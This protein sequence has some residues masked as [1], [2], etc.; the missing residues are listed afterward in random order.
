MTLW[1]LA[2]QARQIDLAH[3]FRVGMPQ[4]PNHPPFRMV[5]ER[6]H[7]DMVRLDGGS[8]AN[9]MIVTG[10]HV[11]T[12]ID[13]LAH[14]SQDG[15]VFGGVPANSLLTARGFS[16]LGVD[17]LPPFVGRGV[18]LDVTAVHGV[19]ALEPGYEVTP[20]DLIA[21]QERIGCE[22]RPGDVVLVGTG[23][24]RHWG[25]GDTFTGLTGG[26]AGPGLE[27]GKW[28][29]QFSP[30]MVGG[31]AITFERIAPGAG[32]SLLPVHNTMLVENGINIIETMNLAPLIDAAAS[33]FL[34]ILAG[35]NLAGA[36]GSPV[37]PL[38]LIPSSNRPLSNTP[39]GN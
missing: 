11:G 4:S 26:V 38:A 19:D 8:A 17:D 31:E 34:L 33:E 13:A 10:G 29:A 25:D 22:I 24:S 20:D 16:R 7:G 36:T 14:V 37:R 18:L 23:W 3:P 12:H 32:H 30:R 39:P 5:I 28:L 1:E 27:A 21:A 6:R 2:A 35:L 15:L 9:E